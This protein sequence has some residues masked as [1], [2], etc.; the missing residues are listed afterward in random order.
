MEASSVPGKFTVIWGAEAGAGF[1]RAVPVASQI[2]VQNGA[3]SYTTGFPPNCFTAVA[4]GG[5]P[6]FGQDFN[7]VLNPV[8]AW[9]QWQ[10]A[11]GPIVYDST[12]QGDIGGYPMGALIQ[13]SAGG[14]SFVS[15]VDNNTVTP[16]VG[17]SGWMPAPSFGGNITTI[18]ATGTLTSY[19]AGLVLVNAASGNITITMPAVASQS[20]AKLPFHF[21]RTD[22]SSNTVTLTRAGSDTFFPGGASTFALAANTAAQFDGNGVSAWCLTGGNFFA[23]ANTWTGA[24]TFSDPVVVAEATATDEAVNANN[25]ASSLGASGYKKYPD[26]NS[27]TGYYIEQWGTGSVTS[28]GTGNTTVALELPIPYPTAHVQ[29][30]AGYYGTAPGG[31]LGAIAGF[32][33]GLDQGEATIFTSAAETGAAVQFWSRGY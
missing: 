6:P 19:G 26:P 18:D 22:S 15:T 31:N 32:P 29:F 5:A 33:S 8:T 23:G 9:N 28:S 16:A 24:N 25:F 27:P 17:A 3:A 7:G 4:A 30:F 13:L 1:I 2:G 14:P 11:G 21:V 20:G 12:F 10:Q